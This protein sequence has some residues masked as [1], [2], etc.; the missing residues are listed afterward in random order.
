MTRGNQAIINSRIA[1]KLTLQNVCQEKRPIIEQRLHRVRTGSGAHQM[2]PGAVM[3]G[4]QLLLPTVEVRNAWSYKA[5]P[6][7]HFLMPS[8]ST[9]SLEQPA[10]QSW[11]RSNNLTRNFKPTNHVPYLRRRPPDGCITR[12]PYKTLWRRGRPSIDLMTGFTS[13]SETS[14]IVWMTSN[15]EVWMYQRETAGNLVLRKQRTSEESQNTNFFVNSCQWDWAMAS[16]TQVRGFKPSRSRRIFQ[17]EKIPSTP[18]FGGEAKPTVPCHRFAACK[19]SLNVK[20]KSAFR[21]NSRLLFSR[22]LK[23]RLSL[24]GSLASRRTWRHLAATVGTSRKQGIQ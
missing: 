16:S 5:C 15:S 19:R 2:E 11:G 6:P 3:D 1:G 21:Q 17:G 4:N 10:S 23:F 9:L 13:N 7:L 20:W 24:L 12:L 14:Q 22:P 8:T 18:S